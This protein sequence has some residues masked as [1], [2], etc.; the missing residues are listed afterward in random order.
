MLH[1]VKPGNRKK[2]QMSSVTPPLFDFVNQSSTGWTDA[3]T[4]LLISRT[5][6]EVQD[7]LGIIPPTHTEGVATGLGGRGGYWTQY[8]F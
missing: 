8:H 5:L 2:H 3:Q 6:F 4:H 7:I 1:P